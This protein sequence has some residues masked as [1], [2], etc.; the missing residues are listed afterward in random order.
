MAPPTCGNPAPVTAHDGSSTF[1]WLGATCQDA[2]LDHLTFEIVTAP[3]HGDL[4]E[5]MGDGTVEYTPEAGYTGD[6]SFQFRASDGDEQSGT[7]SVAITVEPNRPPECEEDETLWE[8]EPGT[9]TEIWVYCFDP[10]TFGPLT[11]TIVDA[12]Q[13]GTV[14]EGTVT[15]T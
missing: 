4:T 2:D 3:A 8:V 10:D 15:Y 11:Y 14:A 9:P 7:V 6:D 5:T 12:P 1:I 13:H